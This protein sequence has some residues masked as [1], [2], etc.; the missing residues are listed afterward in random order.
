MF[1]VSVTFAAPFSQ[2]SLHNLK[3]RLPSPEPDLTFF[4]YEDEDESSIGLLGDTPLANSARKRIF[5]KWLYKGNGGRC[6]CSKKRREDRCSP[7]L[8]LQM[9][10]RLSV[11]ITTWNLNRNFGGL[12]ISFNLSSIWLHRWLHGRGF[13]FF[14][15]FSCQYSILKLIN[16]LADPEPTLYTPPRWYQQD[17]PM[18]RAWAPLRLIFVRYLGVQIGV[19]GH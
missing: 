19:Q 14:H 1:L 7:Q 18:R 15:S 11:V 5:A 8:L 12:A 2:S 17:T 3:L 13:S 16:S 9:D 10:S 6:Q 4:D